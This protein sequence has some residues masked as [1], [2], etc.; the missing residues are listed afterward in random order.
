MV[1][2][3]VSLEDAIDILNRNILPLDTEIISLMDSVNRTVKIIY[4]QK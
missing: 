2:K 3:F 4:I 1:R